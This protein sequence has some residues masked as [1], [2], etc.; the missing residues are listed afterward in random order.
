LSY[1][2]F[3]CKQEIL[4]GNR[5][6]IVK[7]FI[8]ELECSN[9]KAKYSHLEI[10]RTC[11]KCGETLFA[12][13]DLEAVASRLRKEDL[14]K[15]EPSLWRYHE[16]LPVIKPENI[17][18]LGEGMTPIIP[19]QRS[20]SEVKLGRV[21]V[22]DDGIIPTGTFK[23]RGQT[24]AISK[25]KELG[26]GKV[27]IPS[28]GNAAGAMATYASR[29][30]LEA[31]VF[32]PQDTPE[33]MKVECEQMGARVYLVDGLIN[34]AGNIV[35]KGKAS[36]GWYDV[37]T[38]KEPYRVEGKKT[39]GYE[40]AEQMNWTLPNFIIYPTGGGT[41]IIGMWK[42]FEELEQLGWIS[43]PKPKLISVQSETCA[44]IVEAFR[45]GRPVASPFPNPATIASGLRVPY[46]FSSGSILRAIRESGGKAI[47]VT[48]RA[49]LDA[50]RQIAKDGISACPEGAATVPALRDL[51]HDGTIDTNDTVVLYNTGTALKYLGLFEKRTLPVLKADAEIMPTMWN[52]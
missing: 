33:S 52:Q 13:Y 39:M 31:F 5:V 23:A 20:V 19:I 44:P 46:P 25:A 26:I 24:V 43:G 8:K 50:M 11:A 9:C 38:L 49:M 12:R 36:F 32:L 6:V 3:G 37:S 14:L 40:I 10:N 29:A 18:S 22:K 17:V 27:A 35:A 2:S 4:E 21:L 34:D 51:V 1:E 16:V 45:K 30:G 47:A 48:D 7:S 42:A 41:G 28:A 15:R